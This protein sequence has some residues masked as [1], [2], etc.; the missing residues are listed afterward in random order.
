MLGQLHGC[1]ADGPRRAVDEDLLL[2]AEVG[3]SQVGQRQDCPVTH[4]GSLLEGHVGR[5]VR[6]RGVLGH[7]NEL[8]VGAEVVGSD[9]EDRVTDGE[10]GDRRADRFDLAGELGAEDVLPRS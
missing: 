3:P 1:G 4:C 6:E 9:T 2:G 7:A 8:G 5:L 10:L